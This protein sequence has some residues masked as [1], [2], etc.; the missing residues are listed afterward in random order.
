MR[1]PRQ[2]TIKPVGPCVIGAHD[3]GCQTFAGQQFVGAVFAHIV[4]AAQL[5]VPVTHQCNWLLGN[6]CRQIGAGIAQFL[7][8]TDPLP[9]SAYDRVLVQF[10]PAGIG[11]GLRVQRQ[12]LSGV[13]IIPTGK[14]VILIFG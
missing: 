13:F 9:A 6:H 12:R 5:T 1:C 3:T 8:M 2:L 10:V 4:K 14:A 11:I 7:H